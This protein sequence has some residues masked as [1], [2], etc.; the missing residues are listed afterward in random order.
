M[1]LKV[2]PKHIAII[3]DGN[4]RWAEQRNLPKIAG[5]TAGIDVV[6]QIV[7]A[8]GEI[9]I[10]YLSLFAFSS[11]NWQRPTPEVRFLMRLLRNTIRKE[12]DEL[13]ENN[14][15]LLAVGRLDDLP[16]EARTE[17]ARAIELTSHSNGLNLVLALSYGG[18]NEILDAIRRVAQDVSDKKLSPSDI[19][20]NRFQEYLYIPEMP[21]PDLLI[22]TSGEMRISNFYLWQ[23]FYTELWVTSV[24]WPDFT[25]EHLFQALRDYERRER[26]FGKI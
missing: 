7:R 14:V 19:D 2:I 4:R 21:D 5:H 9:G 26:R 20:A 18:R 3:M 15:R 23:T 10:E 25:R 1:D 11:E 8:C 6:R 22:R 17:L 16:S 24:L 13:I 12:V